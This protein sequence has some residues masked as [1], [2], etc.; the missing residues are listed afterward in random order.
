[1]MYFVAF[2]RRSWRCGGPRIG[3]AGEIPG[4]FEGDVLLQEGHGSWSLG[5]RADALLGYR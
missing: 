2:C 1:M 5:M 4:G 3:V